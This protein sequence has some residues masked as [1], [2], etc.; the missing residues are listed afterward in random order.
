MKKKMSIKL[1]GVIQT[2]KVH[3]A[4]KFIFRFFKLRNLDFELY[5]CQDKNLKVNSFF[6]ITL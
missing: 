6:C 2:F 3:L 4:L 1:T 5:C